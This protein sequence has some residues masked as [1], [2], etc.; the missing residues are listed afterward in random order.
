MIRVNLTGAERAAQKRKVS[1]PGPPGAVQAYLFLALFGGG[2]ALLCAALW[3]YE[4]AK[5]REEIR[6]PDFG[7][8]EIQLTIDDPKAYT[9]PFTVTIKERLIV[10]A[11]LIDEICLE[12]ERSLQHMR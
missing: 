3:W 5:I 8:L 7:H 9:K 1:A 4:S 11:E 12:N 6:R 10:E 2:A